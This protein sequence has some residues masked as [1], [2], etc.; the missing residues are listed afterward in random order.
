MEKKWNPWI[1]TD[2]EM[3]FYPSTMSD[4]NF[5]TDSGQIYVKFTNSGDTLTVV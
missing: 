1:Y 3:N 4:K 2:K 5:V